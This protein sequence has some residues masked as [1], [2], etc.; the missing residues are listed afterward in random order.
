MKDLLSKEQYCYEIHKSIVKTSAYHL[1]YRHP[2]PYMGYA[3]FLQENLDPQNA[4]MSKGERVSH[5]EYYI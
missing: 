5:Y 4:P 2:S 1:F 3:P